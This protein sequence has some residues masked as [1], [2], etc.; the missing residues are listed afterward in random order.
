MLL[1]LTILAAVAAIF[2]LVA[3]IRDIIDGDLGGTILF[4]GLFLLNVFCLI[5]DIDTLRNPDKVETTVVKNVV[6][7]QVDSTMT[8]NGADTTKTYT[9]TYWK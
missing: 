7:Y 5:N 3:M 4:F 9:L 6:G 8:I 1:F 2:C